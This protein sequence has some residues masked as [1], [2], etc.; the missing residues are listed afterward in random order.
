MK[1]QL[2]KVLVS[3]VIRSRQNGENN[4]RN[5][6]ISFIKNEQRRCLIL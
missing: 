5:D 1:N 6:R 3:S 2:A 4:G